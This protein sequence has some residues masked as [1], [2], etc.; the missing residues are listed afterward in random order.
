MFFYGGPRDYALVV[1]AASLNFPHFKCP[2]IKEFVEKPV[3]GFVLYMY[4]Y[5]G[6]FAWLFFDHGLL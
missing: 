3:D 6:D 2:L 5:I 4:D 1:M